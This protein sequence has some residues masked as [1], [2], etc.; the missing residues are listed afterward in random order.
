M[1][2]L[3]VNVLIASA[4]VS[5]ATGCGKYEM[6]PDADETVSV[7]VEKVSEEVT[8]EVTPETAK[9]VEEAVMPE[10]IEEE[11]AEWRVAYAE[12]L[13]ELNTNI[14]SGKLTFDETMPYGYYLY[15]FTEDGIPELIIKCGTCEADYNDNVYQFNGADEFKNLGMIYSGHSVFYSN[16]DGGVY[17]Q[18]AHM[19]YSMISTYKYDGNKFVSEVVLEE[20]G[21]NDAGE[22]DPDFEYTDPV[23]AF[24]G[25]V[26]LPYFDLGDPSGVE[27]YKD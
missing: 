17:C 15:D 6:A 9:P 20:D 11:T 5:L 16:P 12:Y 4:L 10:V 22:Y 7:I 14:A 26:Y 8:P 21:Y 18:M 3:F 25:A 2:K 19:G 23:V 24:K 13:D 27:N 1:K